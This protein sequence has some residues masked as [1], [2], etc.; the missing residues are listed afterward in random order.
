MV[1]IRPREKRPLFDRW[2]ER[3]TSDVADLTAQARDV[4]PTAGVGIALGYQADGRY[5]LAIDVDDA[6]RWQ[7]LNKQHGPLPATLAWTSA[8]GDKLLYSVSAAPTLLSQLRNVRGLGKRPGVDVKVAGGQVV[9]PPSIHPSGKPY[10]WHT[11]LPIAELPQRWFDAILPLRVVPPPPPSSPPRDR[12]AMVRRARAWVAKADPA[13]AGQGGHDRAWAVARKLL[14][15]FELNENDAWSILAEYNQ[16]CQPPWSHGELLHK[17]QDAGKAHTSKPIE[18]RQGPPWGSGPPPGFG[19]A[20]TPPASEPNPYDS[21]VTVVPDEWYS[22][23]PPKRS[24]L[25]SDSRTPK[26]DGVLP[27][28]KVAQMIGE[29]GISKTMALI[30]LAVAVATGTPWLGCLSVATQGHVLLLLGEEDVEE[31]QRRIYRAARAAGATPPTGSIVVLPLCGI[32][33]PMVEKNRE[34]NLTD[35]PFLNWLRGFVTSAAPFALVGVDPTSRFAGL[36]AEKD[37][38]AATVFIQALESIATTGPTVF[39]THHVNKLSR[40]KDNTVTASSGRGSSAFVD[41]VRWQCALSSEEVDLKDPDARARLGETVTLSFTKS[42]YSKR[43]QPIQ[44]RRDSD[45]GGALLPL[46]DVDREVIAA[47]RHRSDPDEHRRL[48]KEQDRMARAERER[49]ERDAK[50]AARKSDEAARIERED[51]AARAI[52]AEHGSTVTARMF[53]TTMRARLETCSTDRALAARARVAGQPVV[54]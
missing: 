37:N 51:V 10:V 3:A 24:W 39:S 1:W 9:A 12:S 41:G 15:D 35:A 43:G 2:V 28:G 18:D 48:K 30:Q 21:L 16:R 54:P 11:D 38:A 46:D 49:A 45:N 31:S 32:P 34:G 36:D 53:I 52:L 7:E 4:P 25:L 19:D 17:L 44:L 5:L 8:R 23:K 27:L 13:V 22:T 26:A 6:E 50:E 20:G 29:G 14:Q 47:A 33:C 42:N 40:G